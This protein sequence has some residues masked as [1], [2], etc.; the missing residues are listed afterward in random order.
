MLTLLTI[1]TTV[2]SFVIETDYEDWG[3]WAEI[4]F[5]TNVY[6]IVEFA[7]RFSTCPD[8]R[9][10]AQNGMNWIDL[11]AIL[12][13][14]YERVSSQDTAASG[15]MVVKIIRLVR[16]FRVLKLSKYSKAAFV[17]YNTL[18]ASLRPLS[19]L[20]FFVLIAVTLF[21]SVMYYAE[22][23]NNPEMF[24]SIPATFW[25]ALVTM[26]SVGYGDVYPKSTAGKMVACLTMFTGILVLALPISVIG[27]NFNREIDRDSNAR[28]FEE[29]GQN[30]GAAD[31]DVDGHL[32]QQEL[33]LFMRTSPVAKYIFD[34]RTPQQ[35]IAMF[36]KDGS[37][38]LNHT[39]I[40]G[41]QLYLKEAEQQ[42]SLVLQNPTVR[43]QL[44]MGAQSRVSREVP[45]FE[46]PEQMH[47]RHGMKDT[48]RSSDQLEVSPLEG[49][50]SVSPMAAASS[51]AEPTIAE[52]AKEVRDIARVQKQLL[53]SVDG[54]NYSL[55]EKQQQS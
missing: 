3:A 22:E 25:W 55:R 41:L 54:L 49:S 32:D 37:G 21:S 2:L 46:M 28:E 51:F 18:V 36:D 13:F 20:M 53:N 7:C 6:F 40:Q 44:I 43:M 17:F 39:E 24:P 30:I 31:L 19:F 33:E 15:L 52:L 26:T 38:T 50:G 23:E 5:W 1:A 10:F 48:P 27:A 12:P 11:I 14:I 42:M 16:V 47:M 9:N 8:Y 4:E 29:L 45:E 34:G 35:V